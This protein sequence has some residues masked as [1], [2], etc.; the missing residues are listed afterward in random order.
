MTTFD[1][2]TFAYRVREYIA[3]GS[4][5]NPDHEVIDAEGSGPKPESLFATVRLIDDEQVGYPVDRPK[6]LSESGGVLL[7]QVHYR[8]ASYSVQWYRP[9]AKSLAYAFVA[10]MQSPT[11]IAE[12]QRRGFMVRPSSRNVR[13]LTTII[14]DAWEE[15]AGID[16]MVD[17]GAEYEYDTGRIE[18]ARGRLETKDNLFDAT[19]MTGGE[20]FDTGE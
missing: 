7:R 16:L 12:A 18:T 9:G 19:T 5:L 14:A 20:P 13:D 8:T 6:G 17:Y 2:D 4:G 10:W 11:G 15:R 1:V 3:Q